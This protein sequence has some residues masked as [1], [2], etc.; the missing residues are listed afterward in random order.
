[1]TCRAWLPTLAA[2]GVTLSAACG[3]NP[4]PQTP[5]PP[6]PVAPAPVPAPQPPDPI[7]TLIETSQKH[8]LAG[9]RELN[10]GHLERARAEFDRAVDVLLESPYGA[11]T[12]A[13][14]REHFDRLVDR[15]NAYEVT[16]LAQGDGFVEKKYEPAS[17]DEPGGRVVC[18]RCEA[19]FDTDEVLALCACGSADVEQLRGRE[20]R[21]RAVE[22]VA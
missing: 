12:D 7:T 5:P 22:V 20:L 10:L 16:A 6:P 4:K 2:L 18:R 19:E 8:F 3:S 9:E 15:I 11:R 17:I 21:I 14:L 1:M 13:R